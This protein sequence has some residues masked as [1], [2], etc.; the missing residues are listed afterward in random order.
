MI[1][2]L[3][4]ALKILAVDTTTD[5]IFQIHSQISCLGPE[6]QQMEDEAVQK[7]WD[8]FKN[9]SLNAVALYSEHGSFDE[10]GEDLH[11]QYRQDAAEFCVEVIRAKSMG[12]L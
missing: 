2:R 3:T 5:A 7:A 6:I 11:L 4:E 9:R 8:Q 10:M 1:H 12:N